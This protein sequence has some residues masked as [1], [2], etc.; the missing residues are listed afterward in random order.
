MFSIRI[1]P[2]AP[3]FDENRKSIF[4]TCTSIVAFCIVTEYQCDSFRAVGSHICLFSYSFNAVTTPP[5]KQQQ[6]KTKKQQQQK[7]VQS[8]NI[9]NTQ[10]IKRKLFNLTKQD[11]NQKAFFKFLLFL[12]KKIF[13][14]ESR[15]STLFQFFFFFSIKK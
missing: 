7:T 13:F 5:K 8:R 1:M 3:D 4:L 15:Q 9:Q 12:K 2:E 6:Q 11:K 10:G 14:S